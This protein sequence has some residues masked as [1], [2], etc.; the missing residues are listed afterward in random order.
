MSMDETREATEVFSEWAKIGRDEGMERGHLPAVE[1]I[2][3]VVLEKLPQPFT[4]IDVGCG[5]GWV[6][7]KLSNAGAN[8]CSGVDGAKEMI[9]KARSIDPM[10][11]YHHALLPDWTP[12]NKVDLVHSMEFLY[13]LSDPKYML[14]RIHDEWLKPG[15][16]VAV[17]IDHYKEHEESLQWQEQLSVHMTTMSMEEWKYT[18]ED[19]GFTNTRIWQTEVEEGSMGTLAMIAQR[20][21]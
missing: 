15:G 16:W 2:L 18:L 19:V 13:Y 11:T 3:N 1:E 10:G 7:R 21:T 9:A 8:P 17:G 12:P 4:A 14:E 20:A 6:V 5:N